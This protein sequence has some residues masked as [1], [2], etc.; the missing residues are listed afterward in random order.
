MTARL[1]VLATLV[2]AGAMPGDARAQAVGVDPEAV[3]ILQRTLDYVAGLLQFSVVTQNT[4]EEVLESGQKIQFDLSASVTVQRPNRLRAERHGDII[5]QS[6]YYDGQT[7]TLYNASHNYYASV[8]A[9]GT[10]EA[11]L[12]F[13]RES[14]G[15]IAPASDL[16]YR[17][18]FPLMMQRVYSAI[19]VG[20]T[21]IGGV[22]CDHLA[23]SRP[24]VDFQIWVPDAGQPLPRKYVVTAKESFGQPDTMVVMSQWDLTPKLTDALFSF[25]APKDAKA[26]DF[27]R[28]DASSASTPPT[29]TGASQ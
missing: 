10:I 16:L 3:R 12:D 15:L 4:V 29:P 21:V 6:W 26:T 25:L 1:L 9:P 14:L 23:F 11:M 20:K 22:R 17:N 5:D 7:L 19:V 18:A 13:A 8:P 2:V 27:L 28:L 24:D